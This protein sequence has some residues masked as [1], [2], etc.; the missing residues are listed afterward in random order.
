M[1]FK[2][3][4]YHNTTSAAR[5][6][7]NVSGYDVQFIGGKNENDFVLGGGWSG[8]IG[9]VSFRGEGS[10]FTPLPG[11]EDISKKAVS[12]TFSADYTFDN[13]LYIHSAFLF[14]SMGTTERGEG[15]SLLNPN[16]NLSAKQ[17]SIGKYELFG[18][19]SYPISP[20]LNASVAGIFNPSD[21]SSY[22]GPTV[23][24]SLQD[25][26][27]LMLTAQILLGEAGS[28]YGAMGNTYACFGRLRWSF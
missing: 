25:N 6:L 11:K 21:L 16:F 13:S 2:T 7:F 28:E 3:D 10:L 5:Y 26:L 19:V 1:A 17:L 12:V 4:R 15:I 27:E 22:I 24:I 8:N 9:K 23:T 14:N 18:Q 20:I